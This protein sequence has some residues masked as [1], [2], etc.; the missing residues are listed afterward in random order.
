MICR[1]KVSGDPGC[2]VRD[3]QDHLSPSSQQIFTEPQPVPGTVLSTQDI[4]VSE[5]DKGPGL[6]LESSE[7][8]S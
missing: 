8:T 3:R 1:V 6:A 4:K 7:G 5:T 2:E